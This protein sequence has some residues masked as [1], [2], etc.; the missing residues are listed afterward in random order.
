MPLYRSCAWVTFIHG[1]Q[2]D[3]VSDFVTMSSLS[4]IGWNCIPGL[5]LV[6]DIRW[7]Y[8]AFALN[9]TIIQ[10]SA[11]W[12]Q[13]CLG[14]SQIW[15]E[16]CKGASERCLAS[17]QMPN[18]L[19]FVSI[20]RSCNV[21]AASPCRLWKANLFSKSLWYFH[22]SCVIIML[23]HLYQSTQKNSNDDKSLKWEWNDLHLCKEMFTSVIIQT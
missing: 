13:L 17:K 18:N 3:K 12:Q 2:K 10:D 16:R 6:D 7:A 9:Y 14:L 19:Q 15:C 22:H 20:S 8:F 21:T 1:T 5:H 11:T 4:W 23:T